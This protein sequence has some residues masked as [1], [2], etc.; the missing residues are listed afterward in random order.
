MSVLKHERSVQ[1][2]LNS[3]ATAE[4]SS[5]TPCV[6]ASRKSARMCCANAADR[7]ADCRCICHTSVCC[8]WQCTVL[9]VL[10]PPLQELLNHP[11]LRPTAPAAQD[12]LVGVTKDQLKRLLI[13]VFKQLLLSHSS[14]PMLVGGIAP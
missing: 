12:S 10:S 9:Q 11:F 4:R 5:G 14:P 7:A 13:Q 6:L 1:C 2:R 3:M 8:I